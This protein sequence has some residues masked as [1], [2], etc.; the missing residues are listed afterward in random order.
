MKRRAVLLILAMI[1]AVLFSGLGM[2]QNKLRVALLVKSLGNGF[3][4]AVREGGEEAAKALGNIDIIYTGPTAATAEGQIEIINNLIAQRVDAIVI[5]ANDPN[6]LVPAAKRAMDRGIKVISFDSGVAKDGRLMHLNPS[7]IQLIGQKQI[8]MIAK[9]LG[10]NGGEIAILSATAQATNQNAWIAAMRE[11]LKDPKYS[12]LKLVDT[13]YG[14]DQADKSYREALALFQKHPNLKGII[15]PTTVGIAA[16]AKAVVDQKLVGKVFV[17]GLG[18]PS[19]MAGY[20]KS[21]AVDTFAI[22]NPIDLGYSAVY[23][24]VQFIQGKATGKAGERIS[25]GRMGTI[26]L[27]ANGDAAM[28]EPFTFDKNNVDRFARIF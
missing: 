16:A 19:E 10:A 15:A 24:A 4:E 5:S 20:V 13:V 27:D 22:W 25:I 2:A 6:A 3:F 17:T 28:A 1:G 14:D 7:N 23:A 21:G 11:T 18:L 12:K 9:T 26:T 8:D